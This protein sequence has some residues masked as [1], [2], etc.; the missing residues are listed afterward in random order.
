MNMAA[1]R[2]LVLGRNL[3]TYG[4]PGTVTVLYEAPVST[5]V[6]WDTPSRRRAS[7]EVYEFRPELDQRQ[8]ERRVLAIPRAAV[9]VIPVGTLVSAPERLGGT[10][11]TWRVESVERVEEGHSR[12]VV[13]PVEET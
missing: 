11:Q 7:D 13:V 1:L 9:T 8:G 12:V 4:V 3:S 5:T 10:A 2:D 6:I